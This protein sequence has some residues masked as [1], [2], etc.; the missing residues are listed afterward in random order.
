[1]QHALWGK[2]FLSMAQAYKFDLTNEYF[3]EKC[4]FVPS[5]G[6]AQDM[7]MC[8]GQCAAHVLPFLCLGWKV[9]AAAKPPSGMMSCCL[10][11]I[12]SS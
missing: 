4:L 2:L 3:A 9:N 11:F 7:L 6:A 12:R 1:M 8:V 10:I 5:A